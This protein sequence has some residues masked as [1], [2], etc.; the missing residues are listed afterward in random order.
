VLIKRNMKR[1]GLMCL[2]NKNCCSEMSQLVQATHAKFREQARAAGTR[3]TRAGWLTDM[4]PLLHK[5]YCFIHCAQNAHSSNVMHYKFVILSA[6]RGREMR[7]HPVA[8]EDA[9][10]S[11]RYSVTTRLTALKLNKMFS[12]GDNRLEFNDIRL[13]KFVPWDRQ[14]QI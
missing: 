5:A 3:N 11:P 8:S 10:S 4:K 1:L 7:C 13:L 6:H 12:K 2:K 14:Q 9:D